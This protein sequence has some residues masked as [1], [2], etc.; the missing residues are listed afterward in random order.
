MRIA[1]YLALCGPLLLPAAAQVVLNPP[2]PAGTIVV[3]VD[4]VNVLCSVRDKHGAFVKDLSREQFEIRE[5]GRPRPITHFTREVDTPL[6]VAMLIDVSGSVHN[7]IDA[8]K[9]AAKRFFTEVLRPTDKAMLT[10]FAE[11]IVVW[12]DLTSAMPDL[13]SALD[14]AGPF[15]HM[16]RP[17]E[18]RP[19][20]G[21]LLYD[22]VNLVAGQKLRTLSGRKTMILI[23]DGVD[24]G[25][26]INSDAAVKTAQQ[27]DTV[28]FGI[29]YSDGGG[30]GATGMHPLRSLAEPT[31]GRAF[32]VD[33]SLTLEQV[34]TEIG[35]E[36]RNQYAIGFTPLDAKKDGSFHKLEIKVLKPGLKPQARNGYYAM[37]R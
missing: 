7:V 19:R 16:L 34:F 32:H 36:M 11:L 29:H 37:P 13:Q 10:G 20:G 3:D 2:K 6:T 35:E 1:T 17:A 24:Q 30:V 27:A 9:L 14:Q 21:T 18:A 12:Q 28:I 31:G 25:S 26:L 15:N 8:E 4:L 5:D 23:T 22:A 33:K